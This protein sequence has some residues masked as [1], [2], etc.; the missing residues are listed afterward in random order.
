M[1][2]EKRELTYEEVIKL[3]D[4]YNIV[5]NRIGGADFNRKLGYILD[6]FQSILKEYNKKL[7]LI[8]TDLKESLMTD[9]VKENLGIDEFPFYTTNEDLMALSTDEKKI[10]TEFNEKLQDEIKVLQEEKLKDVDVLCLTEGDIADQ[11]KTGKKWKDSGFITTPNF[12]KHLRPIII[13]P[14]KKKSEKDE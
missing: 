4:G 7:E 13:E 8:K 3:H 10:V 5:A 2:T 1:K 14:E 9:H 6:D 12:W 11:E